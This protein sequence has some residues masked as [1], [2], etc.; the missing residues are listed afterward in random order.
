[1]PP[2]HGSTTKATLVTPPEASDDDLVTIT[3]ISKISGA[4]RPTVSNWKRRH[5]NFPEPA[6]K[7]AKGPLFR[8]TEIL[9]WLSDNNKFP[10]APVSAPKPVESKAA[11]AA[12]G[13][14]VDQ[15]RGRMPWPQLV[16]I[17]L[18]ALSE[19][20]VPDHGSLLDAASDDLASAR[21]QLSAQ[22][23]LEAAQDLLAA[24]S[25]E[26][27]EAI[28]LTPAPVARLMAS[29]LGSRASAYD[30]ACGL[31]V[32]L[33]AA[34][35]AGLVRSVL[36]QDINSLTAE[37]CRAYL[38]L[39]GVDA[40]IHAGDSLTDDRFAGKQFPGILAA[41]PMGQRLAPNTI[42]DA[43]PRWAFATPT[44]NADEA[45]IQHVLHHLEPGG[46]AVMQ[47][48]SGVLSSAGNMRQLRASLLRAGHL[49]AVIQLP[50]GAAAGTQVAT[51]LIVLERP[52]ELVM[53]PQVLI[54]DPGLP[55]LRRENW[56]P[57]DT[58]DIASTVRTWLDSTEPASQLSN[59]YRVVDLHELADGDFDLTPRRLLLPTA[60]EHRSLTEI[61]A[62]LDRAAQAAAA[63]AD[64]LQGHVAGLRAAAPE[65]PQPQPRRP[66]GSIPGLR[67]E[68]AMKPRQLADTGTVPVHTP[69]TVITKE[70]PTQFLPD[71]IETDA[72]PRVQPGDV[73]LVIDGPALGETHVVAEPLVASQHF[74]VIHTSATSLDPRVL[75]QWLRSSEAQARLEQI[76]VGTT[77]RRVSLKDVRSL[78]V[79]VPDRQIQ[80][81]IGELHDRLD[82]LRSAGA[83][84]QA[85]ID[86][87]LGLAADA[88]AAALPAA[89]EGC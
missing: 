38:Q 16:S 22:E 28:H 51:A 6:G 10:A 20:P 86:E 83:A 36:G 21:D 61:N 5:S 24:L 27:R 45:W 65:Q 14:A 47:V 57:E 43:D 74:A 1:M 13:R 26:P 56:N 79:P 50:A 41:P 2:A 52:R 66:L 73:L 31:G 18:A 69:R 76:A 32:G 63:A 55:E 82:Q 29:L 87:L 11:R 25:Q 68:R 53:S 37:S 88:V 40:E 19:R 71:D 58:D 62:D 4:A 78:Q 9:Q 80:E 46:R 34:A 64:R 7:G 89:A 39:V 12:W 81:R 48:A 35:S 72:Q 3:D 33:G 60:A 15:L 67:V 59:S 49:R 85:Q 84:I 8:R 30:P 42:S 77:L 17:V 23:R 44:R 70:P 75:A 54:A